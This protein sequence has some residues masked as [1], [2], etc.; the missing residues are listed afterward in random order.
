V[1]A[2]CGDQ[3]IAEKSET[4]CTMGVDTGRQ[5]HVV[6]SRWDGNRRRV[7]YLGT[8]KE[9]SQLD[10]LMKQFQVSRCVIDALPETHATRD[11]AGR[12][13]R[14]VW[15]NYF[16]ENQKGG[17]RWDEKENVVQENRTEALDASRKAI[18]DGLVILPHRSALVDE[19]AAHLAADAKRLEE[20]PDTGSQVYRYLRTGTDHFSLAFTYDCIAWSGEP[21]G[22]RQSLIMVGWMSQ[23]DIEDADEFS[24]VKIMRMV[25]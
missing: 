6:I 24:A 3:P 1:L 8:L 5:L 16:N 20:D 21:P 13:P 10:D 25:F 14:R 11:F 22:G 17:Y 12:F 2:L 15:L 4:P 23:R 19:F 9:F 7:V 18:R